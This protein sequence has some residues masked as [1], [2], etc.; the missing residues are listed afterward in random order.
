MN[1]VVFN[2]PR[3]LRSFL[4]NTLGGEQKLFLLSP[5]QTGRKLWHYATLYH[6]QLVVLGKGLLTRDQART[7]AANG[8]GVKATEVRP[9]RERKAA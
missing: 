9:K 4:R 2:A 1:N 5:K 6:G 3:S 8:F 7:E